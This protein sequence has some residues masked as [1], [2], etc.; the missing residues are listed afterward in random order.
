ML[1]IRTVRQG[2]NFGI[3]FEIIVF[4]FW[5]FSFEPHAGSVHKTVGH[6]A[7]IKQKPH[8]YDYNK[9]EN[10]RFTFYLAKCEVFVIQ[11]RFESA[12]PTSGKFNLIVPSNLF[13]QNYHLHRFLFCHLACAN[14]I[15]ID[16][17]SFEFTERKPEPEKVSI[18][19][20]S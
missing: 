13:A 7:K 15:G 16:V 20:A 5:V 1:W 4:W 8:S 17:Y 19:A 3:K 18:I 2:Q 6:I 12:L 11:K 10:F 9:S 14:I